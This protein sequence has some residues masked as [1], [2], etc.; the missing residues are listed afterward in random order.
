MQWDT[1]QYHHTIHD[2]E[3]RLEN[4]MGTKS[5]AHTSNLEKECGRELRSGGRGHITKGADY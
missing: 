3:T 4:N 1:Q 2:S 5:G